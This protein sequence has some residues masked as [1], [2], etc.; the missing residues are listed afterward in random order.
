MSETTTISTLVEG[1]SASAGPPLGPE[2]G[3][4][5]AD[6]GEV[7]SEINEKTKDFE[8]MEVPVDVEVDEETGDFTVEVGKPPVAALIKD[9]VGFDTGSGEPN[10]E[11][12]ADMSFSQ[13]CRIARMKSTD[14]LGM[15]LQGCVKEVIG[16]A[17]S[18]GVT[19]DGKD[20]YEVQQEIDAG[21]YDEELEEEDD[22]Q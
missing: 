3:P 4:L 11:K 1:G 16:S 8:G 21:E 9:V 6:V 14:L 19:I 10:R 7:V 5:P 15:D 22:I 2:L 18:M 13:A 20:A 12:V 17:Q